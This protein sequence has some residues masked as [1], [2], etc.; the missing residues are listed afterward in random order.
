MRRTS[1]RPRA[2][3]PPRQGRLCQTTAARRRCVIC[4]GDCCFCLQRRDSRP[5]Y[6]DSAAVDGAVPRSLS[7]TTG[8]R[9]SLPIDQT[10]FDVVA[11]RSTDASLSLVPMPV[12][13]RN[14]EV[15]LP[16]TRWQATI[17]AI[18]SRDIGMKK[19]K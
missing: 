6:F 13:P 14:C 2:P 5:D 11:V 10:T 19:K 12:A 1:R 7:T 3:S 15:L 4:G 17:K 16:T 9:E 8:S 18:K